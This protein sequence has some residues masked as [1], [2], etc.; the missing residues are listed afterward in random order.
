MPESDDQAEPDDL[1]EVVQRAI[2][3]LGQHADPAVR[4]AA[5]PGA[6]DALPLCGLGGPAVSVAHV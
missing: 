4:Y 5:D 2:S 3:R 6:C 1:L